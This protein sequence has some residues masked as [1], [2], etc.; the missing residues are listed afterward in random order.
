MDVGLGI[1]IIVSSELASFLCYMMG[2]EADHLR[3][4][5]VHMDSTRAFALATSPASRGALGLLPCVRYVH[6]TVPCFL[7]ISIGSL[8]VGLPSAALC[9]W[10]SSLANAALFALLFPSVSSPFAHVPCIGV[11]MVL[12]FVVYYNGDACPPGPL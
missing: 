8:L 10:G 2:S 11:H 5:Q 3:F 7:I 1:A 12:Y 9:I 6:S 4:V